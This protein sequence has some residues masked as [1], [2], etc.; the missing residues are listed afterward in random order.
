MH[1]LVPHDEV[2]WSLDLQHMPGLLPFHDEDSIDHV[3][4]CHNVKD[5]GFLTLGRDED[6]G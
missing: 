2:H 5:E 3:V 6:W 1:R 4:A